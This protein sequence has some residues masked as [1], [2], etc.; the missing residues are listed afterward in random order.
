M[1]KDRINQTNSVVKHHVLSS[2]GQRE[3]VPTVVLETA[4]LLKG[5]FFS[6]GYQSPPV[7]SAPSVPVRLCQTSLATLVE[8][9][10]IL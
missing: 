2:H 9:I 5:E 4:R 8:N 3:E 7:K 6:H 1:Q 10:L